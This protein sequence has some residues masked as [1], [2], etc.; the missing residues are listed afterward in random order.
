MNATLKTKHFDKSIAMDSRVAL[1]ISLFIAFPANAAT[2]LAVISTMGLPR[3]G[4]RQAELGLS[5]RMRA[6]TYTANLAR[7]KEERLLGIKLG[8][9]TALK[10]M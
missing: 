7:V 3:D 1:V 9:T 2:C 10:R 5:C 6:T 4:H 8:Q